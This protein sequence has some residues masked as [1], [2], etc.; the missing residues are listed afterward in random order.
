MRPIALLLVT[1]A[2]LACQSADG[3]QSQAPDRARDSAARAARP[4]GSGTRPNII[5]IFT[6]DHAAQAI[7]AYGSVLNETPNIDRLAREGMLF[8]NTF[9]GNSICGPS[10][11]TILTGLLSHANGMLDNGT[12]FDGSQ[13]TFPKLLQ[14]VGYQTAMIGKWH[15]RSD[16]TGFDEW[17][18]LIGQGPYYNPRLK[19]AEGIQKHEGYTTEILT[20]K[21]LDWLEEGRDKSRPFMLMYQH[22][23]PH[24]NW[25]PGPNELGMYDEVVFP[26]PPTLFDDWSG[27]STA[28][29][30]QEMTVAAHLSRFDLK[31]DPP[32]D[33][34]EE[35]RAAWDAVY[36][37]KRLAFEAA[38]LTGDDLVRWKYQRYMQDY[39]ACVAGVDKQI[40]RLLEYLETSGL[41]EDTVVIYSSDQGFY[42]GEHGWY[43]KRWMFEESLRMPFIVRWPGVVEPGSTCELLTQNIDFAPTFLDMA[44]APAPVGMH[45]ESL[46]P[47]L[48]G[49]Q[50]DGWRNSIYYHYYEFPAVH[51][52]NRHYGVRTDRYKLIHYYQKNEWELFDLQIDSQEMRSVHADPAYA[53]VRAKLERELRR[54]Q[55]LYGETDPEGTPARVLQAN[56]R[57]RARNA[58]VQA[59]FRASDPSASPPAN[60]N[61]AGKPITVGALAVPTHGDG[62]L[63]ALGGDSFGFTLHL[64]SGVPTFS[65][66]NREHLYRAVGSAIPLDTPVHLVGG[67]DGS[68]RLSLW[69][70]GQL[71]ATAQ[72]AIIERKP[73]E[74]LSLGRDTGSPVG[75][76]T[77]DTS[78]QGRLTHLSLDWAAPT[79]ERVRALRE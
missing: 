68:G 63:S 25:Q 28:A 65:V 1:L 12:T 78:F 79:Q 52:V 46:V 33:L 56:A 16:P 37:P 59:V 60:A 19:S 3:P 73:S 32:G 17:Q 49:R 7:S 53:A 57:I 64:R 41:A 24:R 45:G 22:K 75:T 11:A 8:R 69:V 66:R 61:P 34:T 29:A 10:R 31:L 15:L 42:L 23:A 20:D 72:G 18:V 54:L 9:C 30:E 21:A 14:E 48:E 13:R 74:G 35:Q 38:G 47:L 26:E 39:L 40:G 76:Y 43:D 55:G 77:G 58:P 71:V 5:F 27:R 67:L 51:Q 44:G 62:V 36:E 4:S 70:D 50:P 6:D 2:P